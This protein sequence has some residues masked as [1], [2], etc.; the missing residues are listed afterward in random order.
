MTRI[1]KLESWLDFFCVLEYTYH[2][3]SI[4]MRAGKVMG[5]ES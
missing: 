4:S 2:I 5:I 1:E 3:I